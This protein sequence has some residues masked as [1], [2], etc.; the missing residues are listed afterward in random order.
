MKIIWAPWRIKYIHAK[1]KK[2]CIFCAALKEKNN[3][4]ITRNKFSFSML[5][6][7]PYNNG[8]IMISPNRHTGKL[9]S[10]SEIEA[11][12]LFKTLLETKKL[13]DKTLSP[14][15]YNIGI[16]IKEAAGAGVTGHLHIHIVPRWK[17]DTNFMS[18]CS[19]TKVISQSLKELYSKLKKQVRNNYRD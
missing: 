12:D 7:F 9:E 1:K 10:L 2:G 8:H 15:G 14:Q 5:N 17:A 16:N 18:V 13:L 3:F 6:T 19:D 4:V 11:L